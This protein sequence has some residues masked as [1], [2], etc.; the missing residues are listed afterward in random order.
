MTLK[1]QGKKDRET[2]QSLKALALRRQRKH[3]KEKD[4]KP[5]TLVRVCALKGGDLR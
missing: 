3:W 4:N 5:K 2:G 1:S